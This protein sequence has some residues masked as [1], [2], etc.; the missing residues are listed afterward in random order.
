M[1]SWNMKHFGT[2]SGLAGLH[3][4]AISFPMPMAEA[5]RNNDVE[6]LAERLAL[7]VAEHALV[8]QGSIKRWTRWCLQR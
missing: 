1:Y 6:R 2:I 8:P 4:L 5:L 7:C 3:Y